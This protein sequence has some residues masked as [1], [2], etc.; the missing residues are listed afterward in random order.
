MFCLQIYALTGNTMNSKLFIKQ[1]YK[2]WPQALLKFLIHCV[3]SMHVHVFV[4]KP[5]TSVT[6]PSI[7]VHYLASVCVYL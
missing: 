2:A 7:V 3:A 5:L 4:N 6:Y 1:A